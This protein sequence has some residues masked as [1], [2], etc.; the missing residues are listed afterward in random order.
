MVGVVFVLQS[1]LQQSFVSGPSDLQTFLQMCSFGLPVAPPM[2]ICVPPAFLCSGSLCF[3]C[4]LVLTLCYQLFS[5]VLL[6]PMH[7]PS[8]HQHHSL[9]VSL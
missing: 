7:A 4:L 5:A 1:L 6:V 2:I 3:L 9:M 8:L